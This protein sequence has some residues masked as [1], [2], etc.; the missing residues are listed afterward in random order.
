VACTVDVDQALASRL[1]GRAADLVQFTREALS[2]VGR[3]AGA[4]TCRLSLRPESGSAALQVEDDGRGF[5]PKAADDR[6]WGLQNLE[7]RAAAVG[8]VVT[9]TSAPGQ[10]TTVRLLLPL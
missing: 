2:N 3:H 1:A 5:D 8:G 9:V 4:K 7:D 10:G 6:G